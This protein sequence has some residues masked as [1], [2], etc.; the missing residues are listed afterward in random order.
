[1]KLIL[2]AVL[3][4]CL[5]CNQNKDK[6]K[7]EAVVVTTPSITSVTEDT[8]TLKLRSAVTIIETKE[9]QQSSIIR[10]I[11][12]DSIKHEMISLKDYYTTQ[13]EI[14]TRSM[15]YSTDKDKTARALAYLDKMARQSSSKPDVYK[16]EFHLNALLANS[17]KYNEMHTKFLKE[18]LTEI[19]LVFP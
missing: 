11:A 16:V 6:S 15:K 17:T 2:I 4:S 9:L 14:L 7:Q 8:L 18:D 3:F 19:K 12:L 13:K 5:S 10:S 1:M